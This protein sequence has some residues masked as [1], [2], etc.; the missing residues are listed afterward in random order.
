MKQAEL[1]VEALNRGLNPTEALQSLPEYEQRYV[2]K[3]P[4]E[5][6]RAALQ[7]GWQFFPVSTGRHLI[8]MHANLFVATD[9]PQRLRSSAGRLLNWVLVTG[10]NSGVFVLEVDGQEGQASLLDLCGDD[11]NWLDTLRSMEGKKRF[12]FFTWPEGRRQISGSRQI[13]EGLRVRGEGDWVLLPP[14]RGPHGAQHSYLNPMDEV[15]APP[16]WILHRVFEPSDAEDPSRPF[17]TSSALH[18]VW[19][20]A[21]AESAHD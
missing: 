18:D 11:W 4:V 1:F 7:N 10:R 20:N 12:I 2:R 14:S 8:G 21:K 16:L 19:S 5:I 3:I 9:N 6:Y 15:V 13:G 17:P